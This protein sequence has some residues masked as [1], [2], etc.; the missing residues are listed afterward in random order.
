MYKILLIAFL[1][2]T[3]PALAQ[4]ACMSGYVMQKGTIV[5]YNDRA[6]AVHAGMLTSTGSGST[7]N[8]FY[9]AG[10]VLNVATNVP[11]DQLRATRPSFTVI[12]CQVPF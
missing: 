1:I 10:G 7:W 12:S 11:N 5:Q 9:F 4:T 6:G 8:L 3:T 2:F